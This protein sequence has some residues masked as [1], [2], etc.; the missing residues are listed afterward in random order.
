MSAASLYVH[1]QSR[2]LHVLDVLLTPSDSFRYEAARGYAHTLV[3]FDVDGR[4]VG[5]VTVESL[6]F[7]NAREWLAEQKV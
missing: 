4:A 1:L 2:S 7:T 3:A 6:G 5:F